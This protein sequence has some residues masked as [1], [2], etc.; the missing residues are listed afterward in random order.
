[1]ASDARAA[2]PL[3]ALPAQA[4]HFL[5]E[6]GCHTDAWLTLDLL[7]VEPRAI[8]PLVEALAAKLRAYRP[9]AICGCMVGGALLAQAL[10]AAVG[11]RFYF[12]ELAAPPPASGLFSARYRLP[13]GLS[14][15]IR[16]ERVAVVDDVIS[17]GSSA[18]ATVRAVHD[19]GATVVAVGALMTLGT[20]GI[21]H[22]AAAGVPLE[23]LERRAFN[24]WTPDECPLCRA[25]Q[26]LEDRLR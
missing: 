12:T 17:A 18:R 19:A 4:G 8:A 7:F 23:A 1:L 20:A 13:P 22:F 25:G 5:L 21:A 3:S 6:S 14:T 15:R 9:T 11:V 26:P 24:V 10:A 16:G 2:D